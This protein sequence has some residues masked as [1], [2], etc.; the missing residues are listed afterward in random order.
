M[1]KKSEQR[2]KDFRK[3]TRITNYTY[4]NDMMF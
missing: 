3:H 1:T 4:F 2:K